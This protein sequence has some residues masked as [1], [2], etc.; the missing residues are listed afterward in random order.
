MDKI[1]ST[2]HSGQNFDDYYALQI[3]DALDSETFRIAIQNLI[4]KAKAQAKTISSIDGNLYIDYKYIG[5][6]P[7]GIRT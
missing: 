1:L 7:V 2:S 4:L 6:L 3:Q 5:P